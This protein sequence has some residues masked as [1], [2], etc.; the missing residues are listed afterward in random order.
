MNRRITAVVALLVAIV[1]ALG[2]Y[3][4]GTAALAP[5]RQVAASLAQQ[6]TPTQQPPQQGAAGQAYGMMSGQMMGGMTSMMGGPYAANATPLSMDQA[7][8]RLE[9]QLA[10]LNNADLQIVEIEAYSQNFYVAIQEKSTGRYAF[11]LIVDRYTGAVMPEMG[12]NMMWNT[13]SGMMG[14]AG[15]MMPGGMMGPSGQMGPDG[16]M[17][18]GGMMGPSGQGQAPAPR[19]TPQN[20]A[21][22]VSAQQASSTAN[23]FLSGYLP[24]TSVGDEVREFYGY[25]TL[26]VQRGTQTVGMVSVNAQNGAVWYHTW[27]GQFF[28][29]WQ[30]VAS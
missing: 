7:R 2:L 24:G 29:E 20:L 27:H 19:Q 28:D 11:E 23:Q 6:A 30:P 5:E 17:G 4:I 13:K 16:M 21:P 8:Q 15:G 18:P 3:A 9:Q 25:Y 12:P 1:L 14:S 10:S 26:E 22:A